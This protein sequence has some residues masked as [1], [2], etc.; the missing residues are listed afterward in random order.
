MA[1][2]DSSSVPQT[3]RAR[4]VAD[5]GERRTVS[6]AA[7]DADPF[8][9]AATLFRSAAVPPRPVTSD[10]GPPPSPAARTRRPVR[11]MLTIGSSA[12]VM[13]VA[14]LLAVSLTVPSEAVAAA[15]GHKSY[16]SLVVP[17]VLGSA[18]VIEADEIQAFVASGDISAAALDRSASKYSA[19]SLG[20]LAA[21]SGITIYST[22]LF[23]NDP[24]AAI[25][26]PFK[27]GVPMS[28][29]YGPRRG[30]M[31]EGIDLAPGN[32]APIQAVADGV[33][34]VAS[35]A[36]GNYGVHVWID[37]VIDGQR[38]STH[39]A[40]MQYGSLRVSSGQQVA[41]GT[42]LG[43]TGNTGRSNGPHLHFEVSVGGAKINPL[44]WLRKNAGR[45]D[46]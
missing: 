33:V 32:G 40:H 19:A 9:A 23:T 13:A 8:L 3:R 37:H 46:Y 7:S 11:R 36:G 42:I 43:K 1:S 39:Y 34:R 4:R 15:Q 22:S 25:Q 29:P 16:S 27:F 20:Q 6:D 26:W 12:A 44:P 38:V 5:G 28:S 45:Y 21:A 10:A 2:D 14:A 31:H 41:V 35:E 18:P 24:D 17:G 30:R